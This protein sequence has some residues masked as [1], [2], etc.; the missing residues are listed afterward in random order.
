MIPLSSAIFI[1]LHSISF[2]GIVHAE[3][4]P[5]FFQESEFVEPATEN[6]L[7][8]VEEK[9]QISPVTIRNGFYRSCSGV[10]NT[11]NV[12]TVYIVSNSLKI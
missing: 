11:L 6:N 9:D 12:T 8:Q 10:N 5:Q 7:I 3:F 2:S 1:Y 4:S